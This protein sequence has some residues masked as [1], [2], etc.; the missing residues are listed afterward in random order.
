MCVV[1]VCGA[2]VG[3]CVGVL[4]TYI[5]I[6]WSYVR[7]QYLDLLPIPYSQGWMDAYFERIEGLCENKELPRRIHFMIRDLVD[8]R[9]NK[10]WGG[11]GTSGHMPVM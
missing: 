5:C 2:C 6:N 7:V 4:Y 8:L 9:K 3:A 11:G 1:H 10:V